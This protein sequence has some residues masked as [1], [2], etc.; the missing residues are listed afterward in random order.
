MLEHVADVQKTLGSIPSHG[1][2][3]LPPSPFSISNVLS[4]PSDIREMRTFNL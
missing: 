2:A 3:K 4:K 1:T